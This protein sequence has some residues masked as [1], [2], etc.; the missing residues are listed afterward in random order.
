MA[1][2]GT[3]KIPREN[4]NES[5]WFKFFTIGQLLA[6]IIQA[7]IDVGLYKVFSAM[8]APVVGIFVAMLLTI[9]VGIIVMGRM[10][11]SKY[12]LASGQP[13]YIILTRMVMHKIIHR[14]LYLRN[15]GLTK[16]KAGGSKK[17]GYFTHNH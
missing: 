2:V 4:K 8:K 7:M 14:Y 12:Q 10:P 5:R 11:Y 16:E 13:F 1:A 15:Y 17:Y 3:H 6:L 9:V